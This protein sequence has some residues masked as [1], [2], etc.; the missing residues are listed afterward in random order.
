MIDREKQGFGV[1]VNE[2]FFE[3]L[4]E[5]TQK[6]LSVFCDKT[7]FL[8][9]SEVMRLIEQGDGTQVWYLLNFAMWWKQHIA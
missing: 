3:L 5:K 7:D 9:K 8:D 1:P 6:E 4:G 2:W